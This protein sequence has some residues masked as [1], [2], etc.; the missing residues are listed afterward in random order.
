MRWYKGFKCTGILPERLIE[1]VA[2]I[3]RRQ[4]LGNVVPVVRA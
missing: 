1:Q 2:G 3:V 4:Q